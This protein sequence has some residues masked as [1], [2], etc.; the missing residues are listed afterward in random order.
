MNKAERLKKIR[1]ML[2]ADETPLTRA[3]ELLYEKEQE[4]RK[5][6]RLIDTLKVTPRV[7]VP[8]D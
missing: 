7:T 4:L 6:Y 1:A 3:A 8:S 5:A 2:L